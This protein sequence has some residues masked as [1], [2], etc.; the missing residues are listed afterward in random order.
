M[1]E[2]Y[3]SKLGIIEMVRDSGDLEPFYFMM[4]LLFVKS[5][6]FIENR[7]NRIMETCS[8]DDATVK[9]SEFQE[10]LLEL[11]VEVFA[12][13]A[14]D[15][16]TAVEIFLANFA[17]KR[18]AI[19]N[20]LTVLVNFVVI[21]SFE[22]GSCSLCAA[23]YA[24]VPW[25]YWAFL[26]IAPVHGLVAT[27]GFFSWMVTRAPVLLYRAQRRKD[28]E[29]ELVAEDEEEEEVAFNP[30]ADLE[31]LALAAVRS[32]LRVVL[33]GARKLLGWPKRCKLAHEFL[34]E[35]SCKR[36]KLAQLLGQRG[37]FLAGVMFNGLGAAW[38]RVAVA[39]VCGP[40]KRGR[41]CLGPPA[42]LPFH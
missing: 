23:T 9:L 19:Q 32:L 37:V 14:A 5:D 7:I 2:Y 3:R 38:L 41:T 10:G 42:F 22:P 29:E 34:W 35:Y 6:K 15:Q 16:G 8:L 11:S 30:I 18:T 20:F 13:E 40:H 24:R 28:L 21:L 26:C 12:A 39:Q 33:P 31:A 36:L 4:P 25:M 1:C 27:I 17:N